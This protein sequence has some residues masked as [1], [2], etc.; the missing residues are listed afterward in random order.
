MNTT[1]SVITLPN[2]EYD[3]TLPSGKVVRVAIY[4][5]RG[6]EPRV[7]IG[8]RDDPLAW[9]VNS[10]FKPMPAEQPIKRAP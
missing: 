7:V 1:R 3:M 8:D 10:T 5:R 2:G 4:R 6:G 9:Y